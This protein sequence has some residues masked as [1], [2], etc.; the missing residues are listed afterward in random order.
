MR[1]VSE[2]GLA[3]VVFAAALLLAEG[4]ARADGAVDPSY[5]RVQGDLTLVLGLGATIAEG[6]SRAEGEVR[7]RYLDSVGVFGAYED[8]PPVG[9]SGDPLRV[10]AG[11]LE[12]RP[13]FLYR[14]LQG[15][16]TRR[17]WLDLVIDS[18]GLE[19]GAL[20]MQPTGT[21]FGSEAAVQAGIGLELPIML[22]ATGLWVGVH[23][24]VRWSE[25]ELA[26]GTVN[27]TADRSV[28][29]AITLAW[30]QVI[31]AH[32]VDVGDEAPR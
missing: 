1:W 8:G 14:W 26:T 9:S 31:V 11:G 2:A 19:L 23:G 21:S 6:G 15:H 12:V 24:G 25:A 17:A 29:V 32:L 7:L 20:T 18:F 30:H 10:L 4:L 27:D 28:F 16:E 3:G 22:D 5:G 13:L